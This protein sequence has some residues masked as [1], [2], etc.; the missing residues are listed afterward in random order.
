MGPKLDRLSQSK[1]QPYHYQLLGTS[2]VDESDVGR[3][4]GS[5]CG[6]KK[7]GKINA[8]G[9]GKAWPI[10]KWAAHLN[11]FTRSY[12]SN[13]PQSTSARLGGGRIGQG[14][15]KWLCFVVCI[16]WNFAWRFFFMASLNCNR[17]GEFDRSTRSPPHGWMPTRRG[18]S[19]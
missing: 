17:V 14:I 19:H 3:K 5:V 11:G 15:E 10:G 12:T 8:L 18:S 6:D 7:W 2:L 4:G 1:N 9:V 16:F 13:T